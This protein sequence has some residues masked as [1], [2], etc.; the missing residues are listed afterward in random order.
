MDA[1]IVVEGY[2]DCI[3]LH[4][5]GFPNTVAALGTAFTSEQA[6]ELR[7]VTANVFVCFDADGAGRAA[8]AK[9]I[10]ILREAGCSARI[11]ALP[12]GDDPD[13]YVRRHG[14][15]AFRSL[16]D[17]AVSWVQYEI[18]RKVETIASGFTSKAEAARQA[19][20]LVVASVPREEWD[21]WRVY[22]AGRLDISVDDLRKSR[23]LT[24]PVHFAPRS[25]D[26]ERP[27]ARAGR[28]VVPG[29]VDAPS[30][31]REVLAI[32]LEEPVL[33]APGSAAALRDVGRAARR[34]PATNRCARA[35][36]RR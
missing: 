25:A 5:A 9:S 36:Q 35:V 30:F 6:R 12:A 24:N 3:A 11:V 20:A 34:A 29:T 7:R 8:T 17:T 32:M 18:D 14:A 1:I 2:L 33:R 13:A 22:I 21:R 10:D 23:L 15:E 16:L 26:G 27:P 28:H 31:E 4:Q 19:E